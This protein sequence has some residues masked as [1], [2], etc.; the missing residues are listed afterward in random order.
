M[1]KWIATNIGSYKRRLSTGSSKYKWGGCAST[2]PRGG[3]KR[4]SST[5][6]AVGSEKP[7]LIFASSLPGDLF[8]DEALVVACSLGRMNEIK[9]T[10]LLDT[11]AIGTAFIDLA[12]MC[13]MCDVLSISFIQ[14]AK[15]KPIRGF[16]GKPAPLITHAIYSTLTV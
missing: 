13:H 11:E 9:T 15:L 7:L 16:N 8:I 3:G 2:R 12:M 1:S 5:T 4:L 14:L 6:V 10:S